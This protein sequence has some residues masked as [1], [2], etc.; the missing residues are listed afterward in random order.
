MTLQLIKFSII[1]FSLSFRSA[2]IPQHPFDYEIKSGVENEYIKGSF[3]YEREN[4]KYYDGN[5][6]RFLYKYAAFDVYRRTANSIDIQKLSLLYPFTHVLLGLSYSTIKWTDPEPLL[7]ALIKKEYVT[8][9]YSRGLKREIVEID[10]FYKIKIAKQLS[11]SPLF[12]IKKFDNNLFWQTK[13][14]L[15]IKI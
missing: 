7:T 9:N 2:N 8:V 13:L 10:L 5:D 4:G 6:I 3:F 12:V 15:R 11:I 14:S 1:L